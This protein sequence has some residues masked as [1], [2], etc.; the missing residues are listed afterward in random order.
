M[1]KYGEEEIEFSLSAVISNKLRPN[2]KDIKNFI[3]LLTKQYIYSKRCRKQMP[4]SK[5]L[6][7]LICKMENIERFI[8]KKTKM[9]V[10]I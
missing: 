1:L 9:R 4:S 7:Y 2:A 10:N 3:C 5:E 8:A 6:K